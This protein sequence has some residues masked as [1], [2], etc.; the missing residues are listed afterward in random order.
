MTL[1]CVEWQHNLPM[2]LVHGKV[3]LLFFFSRWLAAIIHELEHISPIIKIKLDF[4]SNPVF[5]HEAGKQT[6]NEGV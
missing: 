6:V 3:A 1:A 5:C 4:G 2:H